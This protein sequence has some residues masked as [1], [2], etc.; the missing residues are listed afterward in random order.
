MVKNEI[1]MQEMR[2]LSLGWEDSLEKKNGTQS[3]ILG[4]ENSSG[5]KE[6]DMIEQLSSQIIVSIFFLHLHQ[7]LVEKK[8]TFPNFSQNY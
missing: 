1:A 5:C 2:V 3:S 8:N 6:S 4:L 7:Y